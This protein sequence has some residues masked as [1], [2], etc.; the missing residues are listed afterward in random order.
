MDADDS[1]ACGSCVAQCPFGALSVEDVA[2][3]DRV[4]CAGCGMCTMT[5]PEGALH[6]VRRATDQIEPIPEI[7][8]ECELNGLRR[9]GS[10]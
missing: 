10:I 3:V 1:V 8:L 9:A 6:L 2:I 5:C 4:R 7:Q